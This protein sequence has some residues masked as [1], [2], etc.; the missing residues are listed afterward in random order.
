MEIG[1]INNLT[2]DTMYKVLNSSSVTETDKVKFILEN[3]TQIKHIMKYAI[4]DVDFKALMANRTIQKFRPLKNSYTKWGDKLILSKALDIPIGEVPKY[5]KNVTAMLNDINNMKTLSDST[6]EMI[7]TYVYR[8]G[9]KEQLVVFF[10][11]ELQKSKDI[12]KCINN[13]LQYYNNGIADY[14]IRPIHRMDNKTLIKLYNAITTN[15]EH[16]KST[17]KISELDAKNLSKYSLIQI[18]IIQS[19]SK[20]INAIKNYKTLK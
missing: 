2:L 19:N 17:G 11:N 3:R 18:Y 9:S 12:K 14:F 7:K 16:A 20:L 10:N 8:H 13:N 1:K 5:V 4:N 6:T 15:L